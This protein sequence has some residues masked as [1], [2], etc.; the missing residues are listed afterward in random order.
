MGRRYRKHFLTKVIIRVDF[1]SSS[2][3]INKILSTDFRKKILDVFP[4]P[5]PKKLIGKQLEI[6]PTTTKET[7]IETMNWFFH[8]E[9]KEK[10]LCV[11]ADHID[12]AYFKYDSFE[13]LRHDFSHVIESFNELY[14]D[15]QITRFG[16]RYINTIEFPHHELPFEWGE[17][18]SDKLLSIFNIPEEKSIIARAFHNLTLNFGDHLLRFQFG[19]HNPDYPASIK[20]KHFTLDFDAFYQG[21]QDISDITENIDKFHD[22]IEALFENS[23]TDRLRETMEVIENGG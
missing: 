11:A 6:T 19:M 3:E 21:P 12:I 13:N 15:I 7:I 10:T 18:L 9:H 14:K 4:I 5:E 2:G 8:S 16:L 23:I 1:V 17:Y 22:K 20:K